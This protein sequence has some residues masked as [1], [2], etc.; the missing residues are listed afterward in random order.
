VFVVVKWCCGG[1]RAP[2]VIVGVCWQPSGGGV[3]TWQNRVVITKELPSFGSR[4]QHATRVE[5]RC[6]LISNIYVIK[7]SL[8]SKNTKIKKKNTPRAQT[9]LDASFGPVESPPP[10]TL[11]LSRRLQT[12]SVIRP[13]LV[14]KKKEII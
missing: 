2:F 13:L 10:L 11:S 12:I 6:V 5:P 9:K 4:A 3:V 8:V 7:V 1:V 14:S